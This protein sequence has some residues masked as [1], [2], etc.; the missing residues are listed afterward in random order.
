MTGVPPR[1]PYV[2]IEAATSEPLA[3]LRTQI[4]TLRG[5]ILN[6]HR[7]LANCPP[8]LKAFMTMSKHVRDE[9]VLE[10]R[11]R[12]LAI[13]AVARCVEDAYELHHHEPFA[14]ALG[15]NGVAVGRPS[16]LAPIGELFAG[17]ARGR[18]SRLGSYAA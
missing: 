13:V 10:P 16:Q 17:R 1:M 11:I 15:V 12:E 9:S 6:L 3:S 18:R 8:A 5:R 2:A 4:T 14:R 7:V